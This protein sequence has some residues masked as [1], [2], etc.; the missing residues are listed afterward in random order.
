MA[1][2]ALRDHMRTHNKKIK[3]LVCAQMFAN[4]R[5]LENHRGGKFCLVRID[6]VNQHQEK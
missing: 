3:C 1:S 2:T 5:A 4:R 6:L